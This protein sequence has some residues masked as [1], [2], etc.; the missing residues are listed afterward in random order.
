MAMEITDN[1]GNVY[2]NIYAVQKQQ[3]TKKETI[4]KPEAKKKVSSKTGMK[5]TLSTQK[6]IGAAAD[7]NDYFNSLAKLAPSVEFRM[8]NT[9][10]TAKSGKTLTINPAL[11]N[12]MQNDPEQEKETK[13]LIKGVEFMTKMMDGIYKASGWKVVYRHGYIDE[14]GKYRSVSLV[15]NEA[16]YKMSEKLRKERRENSEKLINKIKAKSAKRKEELQEALAEKRAGKGGEKTG[17]AEKLI[18]EKIAASKDGMIYMDDAEF[19]NFIEVMKEDEAE[20]ADT[21]NKPVIGMNLDMQV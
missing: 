19:R 13:E 6:N 5:E 4:S 8:G 9:F 2:E 10:S 18:N 15:R 21:K 1:I 3:G 7:S 20:D 17:K 11:L 16:G 12:K 14:N